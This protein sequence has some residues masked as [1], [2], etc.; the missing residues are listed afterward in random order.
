MTNTNIIL[1][2]IQSYDEID[3]VIQDLQDATGQK[4][5]FDD[6]R[7]WT[8]AYKDDAGDYFGVQR[9]Y[10]GGGVRGPIKTNLDGDEYTIF[11]AG[12]EK[13]ESIINAGFED[14]ESWDCPTGVLLNH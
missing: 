5:F 2:N 14:A 1:E 13:I 8:L 9:G 11:K 12:L 4:V 10:L 6:S 7:A 3:D